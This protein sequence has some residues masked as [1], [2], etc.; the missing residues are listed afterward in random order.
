MTQRQILLHYD[1]EL[2]RQRRERADRLVDINLAF[3]GGK[4]AEQ[5]LKELLK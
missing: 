3:A 4:E 1:A 5:H 2:R